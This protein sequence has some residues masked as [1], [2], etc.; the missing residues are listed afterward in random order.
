M[1]IPRYVDTFEEEEEIDLNIVA[2][3]I[4]AIDIQMQATDSK[5]ADFCKQLNIPTPF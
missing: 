1:N 2:Q 3:E 4:K 5:I